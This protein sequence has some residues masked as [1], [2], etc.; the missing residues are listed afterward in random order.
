MSTITLLLK[1]KSQGRQQMGTSDRGQG[2]GSGVPGSREI[3]Q[4]QI[5]V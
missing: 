2:G 4:G 3:V 5:C 1:K